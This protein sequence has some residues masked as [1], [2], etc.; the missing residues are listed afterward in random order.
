VPDCAVMNPPSRPRV[1]W[2]FWVLIGIP[3]LAVAVLAAFVDSGT[4]AFIL[5]ATACAYIV[6]MPVP[7]LIWLAHREKRKK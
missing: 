1:Q 2:A 3:L 4:G 5:G 6:V 7:A